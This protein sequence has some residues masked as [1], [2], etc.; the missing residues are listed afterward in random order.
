MLGNPGSNQLELFW[1]IVDQFDQKLDAKIA[2]LDEALKASEPTFSV[3]S[4][5]AEEAF[6][7]VVNG[8]KNPAVDALSE[9]LHG[10][11]IAVSDTANTLSRCLN[12]LVAPRCCTQKT[13]RREA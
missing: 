5:T 8:L 3:K 12:S 2:V 4:D 10:I 6:M 13:S 9:D 1:D 11:F 7:E